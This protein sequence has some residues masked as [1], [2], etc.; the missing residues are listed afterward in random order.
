MPMFSE[1]L[2]TPVRLQVLSW[3]DTPVTPRPETA[4][5]VT[6]RQDGAQTPRGTGVLTVTASLAEVVAGGT[7]VLSSI[8]TDE[9]RKMTE[10]PGNL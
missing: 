4:D 3:D 2:G 7:P 1:D 5:P 6:P 8:F 10:L 9:P